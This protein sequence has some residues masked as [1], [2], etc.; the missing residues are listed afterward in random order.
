MGGGSSKPTETKTVDSTG[1]LNNNLVIENSVP[2]HNSEINILLYILVAIQ[3]I[4]LL[5]IIYREHQKNLKKKYLK[6][7]NNT[8]RQ[9]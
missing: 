5:L 7:N 2:V 4:N 6:Q 3:I 1:T 8:A 9:I